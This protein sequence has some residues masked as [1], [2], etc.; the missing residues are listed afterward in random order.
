MKPVRN[1]AWNPLRHMCN[2]QDSLPRNAF[3]GKCLSLP[4]VLWTHFKIVK[5]G[6]SLSILC[7][8][9]IGRLHG[10]PTFRLWGKSLFISV[11][12]S[13]RTLIHSSRLHLWNKIV[14][15]RAMTS[16]NLR[17]FFF[18]KKLKILEFFVTKFG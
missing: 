13:I 6:M 15:R 9:T 18:K 5:E 14:S 11:S 16:Q 4:F 7:S 2:K 17:H 3:R 12:R 8:K 1:W 10:S